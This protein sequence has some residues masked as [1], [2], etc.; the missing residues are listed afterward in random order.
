M[1]Y[2]KKIFGKF[3]RLFLVLFLNVLGLNLFGIIG[4]IDN[5]GRVDGKDLAFLALHYGENTNAVNYLADLNN[6]GVV[7][8]NDYIILSGNFGKTDTGGAAAWASDNSKVYKLSVDNGTVRATISGF[9]KAPVVNG[10]NPDTG[11]AWVIDYVSNLIY[12]ISP[13]VPMEYNVISNSGYHYTYYVPGIL[14]VDIAAG[15]NAAVCADGKIYY[16]Y[17]FPKDYDFTGDTA[18]VHYKEFLGIRDPQRALIYKDQYIWAQENYFNS[19]YKYYKLYL[20]APSVY[21]VQ[22]GG[23]Y[24]SSKA[25]PQ[26]GEYS[27]DNVLDSSGNIVAKLK[28]LLDKV[29]ALS[30][31]VSATRDSGNQIWTIRI[32]PEDDSLWYTEY[33]DKKLVHISSDLNEQF[34]YK[35]TDLSMAIQA[36]DNDRKHIWAIGGVS[37]Q[38]FYLN[39]ICVLNYLG[40]VDFCIT[41]S[42]FYELN[43]LKLFLPKIFSGYPTAKAE[44]NITQGDY[45]LT[46]ILCATNSY[47]SDGTIVDY[48]WDFNGDGSVDLH[49]KDAVIVTNEYNMPGRYSVM[50]KVTD[51]DGLQDYDSDL[52]IGVGP[53]TVYPKASVTSGTARLTVDFSAD[54]VD[55]LGNGN[56]ENYQWDFDGDGVF[57][58]VSLTTPN[59]SYIYTKPGDYNAHIKVLSKAGEIAEGTLKIHVD[60]VNPKCTILAYTHNIYEPTNVLFNINYSDSDG[61]VASYYADFDS[62]GEFDYSKLVNAGSGNDYIKHFFSQPGIYNVKVFAIDN[63][64]NYSDTNTA[65]VTFTPSNCELIISPEKVRAI[66][67]VICT[68]APS[69]ISVE[70]ETVDWTVNKYDYNEK[71]YKTYLTAQKSETRLAINDLNI[72]GVY[73][74][75]L[76]YPDMSGDFEVYSSEKP[77]ADFTIAPEY[78]FLGEKVEFDA[79][80]SSSPNGISLYEWS[81]DGAY[82][83]DDA[84]AEYNIFSGTGVRT[85]NAAYAGKY[86]WHVSGGCYIGSRAYCIPNND[87]LL[88]TFYVLGGSE[89]GTRYL[90]SITSDNSYGSGTDTKFYYATTEWTKN[91]VNLSD[92]NL[93]ACGKIIITIYPAYN[94]QDI[95]IDNISLSDN[96]K[97][98]SADASSSTP[99]ISHTYNQAGVYNVVL[100]VTEQNGE[101]DCESKQVTV[102]QKPVVTITSPEAG[103]TYGMNVCFKAEVFNSDYVKKYFWDFNNDGKTDFT[104]KTLVTKSYTYHNA[105]VK[106]AA[107]IAELINGSMLT[108]TVSFVVQNNMPPEIIKYTL[109]S[110]KSP[111]TFQLHTYIVANF[112][113][114]EFDYTVWQYNDNA[115]VT[116]KALNYDNYINTPGVYTQKVTIVAQNGQSVSTQAVIRALPYSCAMITA[117]VSPNPA[118]TMEPVVLDADVTYHGWPHPVVEKYA[119]DLNDD[120]TDDWTSTTS[121][122]FT[123]IFN[124]VGTY[125]LKVSLLTTNGFYDYDYIKLE[126]SEGIQTNSVR[127]S[128]FLIMS[129]YT[130]QSVNYANISSG[131]NVLMTKSNYYG[132]VSQFIRHDYDGSYW[133]RFSLNY[134]DYQCFHFDKNMNVLG[135]L[136]NTDE[137]SV[138][139]INF[140]P[141]PDEDGIWALVQDDSSFQK[142]LHKYSGTFQVQATITNELFNFVNCICALPDNKVVINISKGNISLLAIYDSAG[143][144]IKEK[145]ISN[146]ISKMYY[147]NVASNIWMT[148]DDKV[149]VYNLDFELIATIKR[150]YSNNLLKPLEINPVDGTVLIVNELGNVSHYDK[151]GNLIYKTSLLNKFSGDVSDGGVYIA[152]YNTVYKYLNSFNLKNSYDQIINGIDFIT[153]NGPYFEIAPQYRPVIETDY[154]LFDVQ[155]G[156]KA[157]FSVAAS[158]SAGIKCYEWDFDGDGRYDYYSTEN[159]N[160]TNVYNKAG[161]FFPICRVTDNNGIAVADSHLM[162]ITVPASSRGFDVNMYVTPHTCLTSPVVVAISVISDEKFMKKVTLYINNNFVTAYINPGYFTFYNYN[163]AIAGDYTIK[164]VVELDDGSSYS[165]VENIH[166]DSATPVAIIGYSAEP[167]A[168]PSVVTLDASSSY[169]NGASV[170]SIQW[171]LNNDGIYDKH[172]E[173]LSKTFSIYYPTQVTQ[174]VTLRVTDN[175]GAYGETNAVIVVTNSGP[176]AAISASPA[177]GIAPFDCSLKFSATDPDGSINSYLIDADSDGTIDHTSTAAGNF[178]YTYTNSPGTYTAKLF[179]VDNMGVTGAASAVVE[180]LNPNNPIAFASASP[181]H[182]GVPLNVHFAG[183]CTNQPIA[184]YEWDFDGDGSY[185]WNST[186]NGIVDYTYESKGKYLPKFRVTTTNG[187][188]DEITLSVSAGAFP[189]PQPRAMPLMAKAPQT[190]KFTADG[191]DPDGTILYFYWDINNK[192]KFVEYDPITDNPN[193]YNYSL[194]GI[195]KSLLIAKDD[196]GL[197]ATGEVTVTIIGDETPTVSA[198]VYPEVVKTGEVVNF[199]GY[200]NDEDGTI[201]QMK[202]LFGDGNESGILTDGRITHAYSSSGIYEAVFIAA[203]DAGNSATASVFVSVLADGFPEIVGSVTPNAGDAPLAVT[204]YIS[205][206]SGNIPIKSYDIDFGDGTEKVSTPLPG[207]IIHNYTVAGEYTPLLSVTDENGKKSSLKLA[208]SVGGSMSISFDEEKIDPTLGEQVAAN[209][210]LPFVSKVTLKVNDQYGVT[211]KILW[212]EKSVTSGFSTVIWDGKDE[213]GDYVPDGTYYYVAS[214]SHNGH[215]FIYDP[216]YDVPGLSS[217]TIDKSTVQDKPFNIYSDNPLMIGFNLN[218]RSEIS[219]YMAKNPTGQNVT[220]YLYQRVKTIYHHTPLASGSQYARWDTTDD[221]GNVAVDPLSAADY[222]FYIWNWQLPVNTVII[223]SKPKISDITIEGEPNFYSA[224]L[225]PYRDSVTNELLITYFVSKPVAKV[226]VNIMKFNGQIV[227]SFT[228]NNVNAGIHTVRW[229]AKAE[230]GILTTPDSYKLSISAEDYEGNVSE[231]IYDLFK[232]IY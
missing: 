100:R 230:N 8:T 159:N 135:V 198:S 18:R 106:T 208:V 4:D 74:V 12:V 150:Y 197:Q 121:P 205:E 171:D 88:L 99:L 210:F 38:S 228:F 199:Y 75:K 81:F 229:D 104:S 221:N 82:F 13:F 46:V 23:V 123:N 3:W 133:A 54:V 200:A 127:E 34:L 49:G 156:K 25:L 148:K 16:W 147:N 7:N 71:R 118:R 187:Y 167:K 69:V 108:T 143:N 226:T 190:V 101:K 42:Q 151:Y 43:S 223:D 90:V 10:I 5:S 27:P 134:Y 19:E 98:F 192:G 132:S 80:R 184:L 31:G 116:N 40:N 140:S 188:Q 64:G 11:E 194:P 217:P 89:D 129:D 6:D 186:S 2:Y 207:P 97:S 180:V 172:S 153:M 9:S 102:V 63:E 183:G 36:V 87:N 50:L 146:R 29:S 142:I 91:V 79:S 158:A 48:A 174:K 160:V 95:Y 213:N 68:T 56:M 37:Y 169:A 179:A 51:N 15:T 225:N 195:Y 178:S 201:A 141:C 152:H 96:G 130:M 94:Y 117:K 138:Q 149:Y 62:D 77:I 162:P 52:T 181:N 26:S 111:V 66:G 44:A 203:D 145:Y 193:S 28:T 109:S 85:T 1:K 168:A 92:L 139:N 154:S 185:E 161:T 191:I 122:V 47:D 212:N 224:G 24:H 35:S 177:R 65:N 204:F 103:K 173:N 70:P 176:R 165:F 232:L 110:T 136:T 206:K 144:L 131:G 219:L 218:Y 164:A 220:P 45:P 112:N 60:S 215:K 53:L 17:D 73:R 170:K 61:I 227:K 211:K 105:G 216:S 39:K 72:P 231:P 163:F 41:D 67:S 115:A 124:E 21:N 175:T 93:P 84:E 128:W 20:T 58:Y 222:Y 126:V 196:S 209:I 214:Y 32:N 76:S 22:S 114:S 120:G 83:Y 155:S 157:V 202:W 189:I 55:G 182:G 86:S 30:M 125:N 57:D 14:N 119:W 107:L 137:Y 59:T 166:I 78:A 113:E 33:Y